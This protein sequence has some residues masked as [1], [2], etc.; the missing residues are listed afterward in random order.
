M[1]TRH[2]SGVY[3]ICMQTCP[4]LTDSR[5]DV[6]AHRS[7]PDDMSLTSTPQ[8]SDSLSSAFAAALVDVHAM[9]TAPFAD[10]TL[11]NAFDVAETI[12]GQ[13]VQTKTKIVPKARKPRRR[14]KALDGPP[15]PPPPPTSVELPLPYELPIAMAGLSAHLEYDDERTTY[16]KQRDAQVLAN[17]QKLKDLG[18]LQ[19][20]ATTHHVPRNAPPLRSVTR[21][22]MSV[23]PRSS[24]RVAA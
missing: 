15:A 16:E 7:L 6:T 5:P 19:E 21:F 8:D 14:A 18:I 9:D 22:L 24:L 12:F 2:V 13:Y 17:E 23:P 10:S 11:N 4:D 1:Q 20:C 3:H